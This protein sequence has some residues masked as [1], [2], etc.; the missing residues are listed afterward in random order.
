MASAQS[1]AITIQDPP[2][3]S[4]NAW[5][6]AY[7]FDTTGGEASNNFTYGTQTPITTFSQFIA[8]TDNDDPGQGPAFYF[9]S[10]YNKVVVLPESAFPSASSSSAS[11]SAS[12]SASL[13]SKAKRDYP[14][15]D[16]PPGW[17]T[18][19]QKV[20][21]GE[22][23]WFCYWN[24]TFLE[25]FIYAN[26]NS[27]T[28]TASSSASAAAATTSI[29]SSSSSSSGQSGY[30]SSTSAQVSGPST[31][32]TSMV[33]STS[34]TYPSSTQTSNSK[35]D[36]T[37]VSWAQLS[38]FGYLVKIEERRIPGSPAPYCQQYQILDDGTPG[39]LFDTNG[40]PINIT[41]SEQDPGY[42]AYQ[43]SASPTSSSSSSKLRR[44]DPV[45]GACHCQWWSGAK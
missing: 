15:L 17:H 9:Q 34:S 35:R 45:N 2:T 12:A 37:G 25:G 27:G 42:S 21:S 26:N 18:R 40:N 28:V 10:F 16:L 29:T 36:S 8:V 41:L 32:S 44:S 3:N 11:V 33:T 6:G 19:H 23:P 20:H 14:H 24:S 5:E 22:K 13:S 31:T 43:G 39:V 1:L 30:T 38:Q 7:L 4:N